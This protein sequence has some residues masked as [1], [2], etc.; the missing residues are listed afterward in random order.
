MTAMFVINFFRVVQQFRRFNSAL[1]RLQSMSDRELEDI[2]TSRTDVI[3]FAL[4][5]S[6]K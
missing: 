6:E 1:E 5:Q 2:G 4:E 3:R